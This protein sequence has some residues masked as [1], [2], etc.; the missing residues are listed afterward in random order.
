[1]KIRKGLV[2]AA[3]AA[4][5]LGLAG[6][7][8]NSPADTDNENAADDQPTDLESRYGGYTATDEMPAFG[9]AALLA[10][11][12]D[13]EE[14]A[15]PILE[16]PEVL[17]LG[18]EPTTRVYRLRLAWGML[19]ADSSNTVATDWSG[20]LRVE[21]GAIAVERVLRFE[22]E[23][24]IVRPRTDPELLEVVSH[25]M[26]HWD[27][28]VLMVLDPQDTLATEPNRLTVALGPFQRIFSMDELAAIDTILDVDVTGNQFSISGE[29]VEGPPCARGFL[30]GSWGRTEEGG[31]AFR[32][33]WT[34]HRGFGEGFVQGHWGVND[35][36]ACVLFGKYV[37][38][39]GA[40][41]GLL[42]GKWGP[43][44]GRG[45]GWFRG[46]WYSEDERRSGVFH[47]VWKQE[48]RGPRIDAAS[49][50]D[51][52]FHGRWKAACDPAVLEEEDLEEP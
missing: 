47:G 28:L 11:A 5:V 46:V 3:V 25:T 12:D 6:C 20:S 2:L 38:E 13:G 42:R 21:R 22:P 24:H 14:A 33:R 19:E 17:A 40:F 41:K 15:D 35:D 34:S 16:S 37:D 48:W 23:D 30:S 44:H 39:S 31:G 1:M 51:G 49:D 27:G 26:P 9:D 43:K 45:P 7:G 10:E 50:P 18:A 32:G 4:L 36:G 29:R 52:F 8:E